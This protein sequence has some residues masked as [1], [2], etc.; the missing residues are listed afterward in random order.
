MKELRGVSAISLVFFLGL[1]LVPSAFAQDHIVSETVLRDTLRDAAHERERN[2]KEV[3][4][5]FSS[6]QVGNVLG[7]FD[8]PGLER[9]TEAIPTLSDHELA[10]LAEQIEELDKEVN[11][12][13]LSNE[14]LTYIVIALAAAVIVLVIV[15]D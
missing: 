7:R 6:P 2:V 5:F 15:H 4:E 3:G 11:A 10:K 14:Q 9:I 1:N 8:F 13:A 12:G